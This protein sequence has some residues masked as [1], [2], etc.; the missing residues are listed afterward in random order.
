MPAVLLTQAQFK[1]L[2]NVL[3][4]E[5]KA[6]NINA[7]F[8]E[9][10]ETSLAVEKPEYDIGRSLLRSGPAGSLRVNIRAVRV[11]RFWFLR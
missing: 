4:L 1:D 2:G 5:S 6:E 7:K 11:F 9:I 10:S 8:D 3:F